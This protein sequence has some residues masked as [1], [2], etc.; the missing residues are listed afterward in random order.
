MKRSWVVLAVVAIVAAAFA[1][2]LMRS[3]GESTTIDL[4][5]DFPNAKIKRPKP[6]TFSI[7][8]ASIGGISHKSIFTADPSR[9][10]WHFTVPQDGWLKVSL[11]IKEQGW[12]MPG[13]GVVFQIGISTGTA[14]EELLRL[15]V[16]PFSEPADR[17]WKDLTLDLSPYSGKEVDLIF[18]T[19][20]SPDPPH[21]QPPKDDRN[22]D[23]AL[24][25]AP[26]VVV[27]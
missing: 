4:V 27:K 8:D 3:G 16:N 26:R 11:G 12:T 22:G 6:E 19:L 5:Q 18:N 25:G 7:V 20:S 2:W 24:W 13:D 9:I 17:Q 15:V 10:G 14:Y 21:G 23:L 1:V